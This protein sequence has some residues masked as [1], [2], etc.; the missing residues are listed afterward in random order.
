[1]ALK[2]K[3]VKSAFYFDFKDY[4][5]EIPI[6]ALLLFAYLVHSSHAHARIHAHV[7]TTLHTRWEIV[8]YYF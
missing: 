6:R 2:T 4:I 7:Q 3:D 1:M 8:E 5:Y